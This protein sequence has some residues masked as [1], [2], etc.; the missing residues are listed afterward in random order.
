MFEVRY[1]PGNTNLAADALSRRRHNG[2]DSS[3]IATSNFLAV[4]VLTKVSDELI[5]A[6]WANTIDQLF[7]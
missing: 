3:T 4:V 7:G 6:S 5:V 1:K 2:N